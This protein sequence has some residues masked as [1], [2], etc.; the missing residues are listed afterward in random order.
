MSAVRLL[1]E[2]RA[3]GYTGGY[4]QLTQFLHQ[5]R[6]QPT[7]EPVVRFETPPGVQAQFD[8]AEF[9]FPW[10]FRIRACRLYRGKTKG[11][12]ERPV[13]YVRDKFVYGRTILGDGDLAAQTVK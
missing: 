2:C 3:A 4:S 10:G 7:P 9:R 11:K 8:F 1:A 13:G 5:V 6:P 12:V